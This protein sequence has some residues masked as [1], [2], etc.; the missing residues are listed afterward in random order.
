MAIWWTGLIDRLKIDSHL[1]SYSRVQEK[2]NK[3]TVT[4]G[5]SKKKQ[6]NQSKSFKVEDTGPTPGDAWR[7]HDAMVSR[8]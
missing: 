3:L 8:L 5:F 1:L 7:Q 2:E 4:L 6:K